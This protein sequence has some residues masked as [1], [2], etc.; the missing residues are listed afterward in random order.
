MSQRESKAAAAYVRV[1]MPEPSTPW[2]EA[3]Y[4]VVDLELTGL[5][6]SVH[7]IISF[8]AVTVVEGKVR[9]GDSVYRLVRPRRFPDA[10]TIRIHGLRESD[11]EDAPVLDEV[12]DELLTSL[13]GRVLVAHV[14]AVEVGFLRPALEAQGLTLGNPVVDTAALGAELGRLTAKRSL[15]PGRNGG[16]RFAVSSPGLSDLARAL[17]LPVHRPHHADGDALTTAQVFIALATLLEP[18]GLQTLRSLQ[19]IDY[20]APERGIRAGVRRLGSRLR[21]RAQLL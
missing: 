16:A 20:L 3:E 13:T 18:F 9:V 2:R 7:E 4:T 10:D 11:L 21:G 17:G 6:P 12:M 8:A 19:R 15:G 14:A 1:P 5:D